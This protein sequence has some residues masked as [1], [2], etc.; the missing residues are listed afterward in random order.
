MILP[1]PLAL[2]WFGWM[3][4]A[5]QAAPNQPQ[6]L[7]GPEACRACHP[8]HYQEWRGSS[9]AYSAVDPIVR[10]CNRKALA[11]TKGSVQ[12]LC[13][14]CHVPVG[15]RAG[16]LAKSFEM[17]GLSERAM[18]GVS[19]EICHR[20]EPPLD[21]KPIANASFELSDGNLVYG[22]LKNPSATSAHES[23]ESEF[24][25]KSEFC[26]SCHDVL[27]NATLFEKSFAQWGASVHKERAD[28]C[29]NCHMRRY[30]GQAAVGGPFRETLH[31][32][33]FPAVTVPLVPFPNKGYQS[34]EIQ[35]LL[36]TAARMS[37]VLPARVK[38]GGKLTFTVRVKNSG[39]GHNIPT[40]LA[41]ERQMWIE[42]K[43]S[44]KTG[45]TLFQSGH[46]DANGDLMDHHSALSPGADRSL[47]LFA[48][49]FLNQAGDEVPF[50]WLASRVEEG[51]IKPMEERSAV[52]SADV[53]ENLEGGNLRVKVRLL[54]RPFPP[55]AL[56]SLGLSDLAKENP[57]WE[58]DA[59]ESDPILV[60]KVI[61]RRIDWRIPEDF[62][63]LESAFAAL[64]NGDRLTVGP[65]VYTL[66]RPLDF[67]G[68]RIHVSSLQGSA[69]TV[70]KLAKVDDRADASVIVCKSGEGAETTLEG[71][72]ITGGRGSNLDGTR[73]GGGIYVARSSPT[74]ISNRIFECEAK[75]GLG[76]GIFCDSGAPRLVDNDVSSCG[77]ERGGGICIVGDSRVAFASG[78]VQGSRANWG[79]GIY[80]GGAADLRLEQAEIAGNVA[81]KEGGGIFAE[82]GARL[83]I[84]H[85][86]VV[87]NRAA[88]GPA[89]IRLATG[90]PVTVSNSILYGNVPSGGD[91]SFKFSILDFESHSPTSRNVFPIFTDPTGLWEPGA[92]RW[93]RGDYTLLWG[94]PAID[95]GDPRFP[96]ERDDSRSDIGAHFFE[97]KLKAFV[98]GDVNGDGKVGVDD[99]FALD[100]FL[101]GSTEIDCQDSADLNDDGQ[102]T[103]ADLAYLIAFLTSSW[104]PP[105]LPWPECGLD[106]TPGEGLGCLRKAKPCRES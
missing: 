89:S 44:D 55:Y 99:V 39:A 102:I 61:E 47:T 73:V 2:L 75:G 74:L 92:G 38:S 41:N 62:G 94:S 67:M 33:N 5:E 48:D 53:P 16:E 43:V 86:T 46:L 84:D 6:E 12:G 78:T 56:S 15:A 76:G 95:S 24:I 37:V 28:K 54:F 60:A 11:D 68:K 8:R 9:H 79:G 42:V 59:F 49:R 83:S 23:V 96:A 66:E 81:L 26:G 105:T 14:N 27:H 45:G 65:G 50:L 18:Q 30:S 85:C 80:L 58:M 32:H 22:R 1:W 29:Q 82:S 98:R 7:Q 69:K 34:E 104:V 10:A 70:L 91:A 103:P 52:Y 93:I 19:C 101:G 20:M 51:S 106:P 72:T 17:D 31:R 36:R 97:Q 87:Y 4:D 64:Q 57:I 21:G 35:E 13:V 3:P 88:G 71:F 40:G 63:T 77:A 90:T 100:D 25:G